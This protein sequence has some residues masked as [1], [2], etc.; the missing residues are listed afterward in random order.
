MVIYGQATISRNFDSL[1][2]KKSR[3]GSFKLFR[4]VHSVFDCDLIESP[5][6]DFYDYKSQI[7]L[8][9]FKMIDEVQT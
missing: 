1:R 5:G 2:L 8:S 6:G 3:I 9:L 7:K 4:F